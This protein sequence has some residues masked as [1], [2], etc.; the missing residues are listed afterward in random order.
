MFRGTLLP[1][2]LRDDYVSTPDIGYR[3]VGPSTP[4]LTLK[5]GPK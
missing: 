2:L 1:Q 4:N 3:L 5:S